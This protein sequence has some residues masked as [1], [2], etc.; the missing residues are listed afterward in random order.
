M[1]VRRVMLMKERKPGIRTD[2]IDALEAR[3]AR[4]TKTIADIERTKEQLAH[5]GWAQL[6]AANH[7]V[8]ELPA[9]SKKPL[10]LPAP[11]QLRAK[12]NPPAISISLPEIGE[13]G[14]KAR[15]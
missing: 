1:K 15:K 12:L 3:F 7:P 11:S 2:A 10:L 8:P 9:L 4:E 13:R 6:T 14:R 5:P